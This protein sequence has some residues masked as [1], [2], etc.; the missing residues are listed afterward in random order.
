M[1]IDADRLFCGISYCLA[2]YLLGSKWSTETHEIIRT[3]P[4]TD[5]ARVFVRCRNHG[6]IIIDAWSPVTA[7]I[8][9]DYGRYVT[10]LMKSETRYLSIHYDNTLISQVLIGMIRTRLGIGRATN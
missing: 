9:L 2:L 6:R 7:P 8:R 5:G 4:V 3:C 10:L 1:R